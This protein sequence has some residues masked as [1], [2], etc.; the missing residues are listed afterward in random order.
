[1]SDI[2]FELSE[3]GYD[4][5]AEHIGNGDARITIQKDGEM[6][7][8]FKFPS[9]KIWNIAAHARDIVDGLK[10]ESDDGLRVAGSDLLGGNAYGG[11]QIED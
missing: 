2:A 6:I 10:Q 5:K 7:R 3:Q 4:F 8:D 1:M 11:E 9:Y